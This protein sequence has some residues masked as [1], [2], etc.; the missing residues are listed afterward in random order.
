MRRVEED[1]GRVTIRKNVDT[2]TVCGELLNSTSKE[3]AR[4]SQHARYQLDGRIILI[5]T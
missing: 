1:G 4:V 2:T 5:A 3:I